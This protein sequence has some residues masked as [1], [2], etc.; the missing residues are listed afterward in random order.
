MA[1]LIT[2][3]PAD[4]FTITSVPNQTTS[5]RFVYLLQPST[6]AWGRVRASIQYTDGTLQTVHYYITRS[7]PE[8]IAEL[9]NFLTTVQ[10]F[11]DTS[12][13]FGRAPSIISYDRSIN[14]TIL[15]EE[16]VWIAGLSD[17]A[18]AGSWLA[19]AMK[20]VAQPNADEVASLDQF[21]DNVLF[22]TLQLE[23]YSV[24]KS[25]FYHDPTA[26]P[27]YA[28]NA[29]ITWGNWWSWDKAD[30]YL[31][32]RAY[33]YIHVTSAYWALYRVARF[34]S[35]ITMKHTWD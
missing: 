10:I 27:D 15:Q 11:T 2:L 7:A 29:S 34:Y 22:K 18:G 12:D 28:Y 35:S 1:T 3:D 20:Q 16:R 9:G 31:T 32:D 33:D 23:D 14:Q 25:I 17:E 4:A 24:R 21:I 19:A 13:P 6:S 5:S 26:L 30:A 8:T